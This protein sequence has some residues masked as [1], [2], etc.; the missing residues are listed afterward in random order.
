MD[1]RI[2]IA[3]D[4]P[5]EGL[6]LEAILRSDGYRHVRV[7]SD[8][9]EISPLYAKWPFALLIL[10]MTI[11]SQSCF[12]VIERMRAHME[13]KVLSILALSASGDDLVQ[14]RAL[15]VGVADVISRPF[16]RSETLLRVGGILKAQADIK[17]VF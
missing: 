13:N 14:E 11:R 9:R 5:V 15:R 2:F 17:A 3:T 4:D 12:V 16:T 8:A 10:D 7:T 6:E 1:S